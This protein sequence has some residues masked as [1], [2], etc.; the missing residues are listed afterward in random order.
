RKK[1][2]QGCGH[3]LRSVAIEYRERRSLAGFRR[4]ETRS[5][6]FLVVRGCSVVGWLVSVEKRKGK[7]QREEGRR[8]VAHRSLRRGEE[9][10]IVSLEQ[11]MEKVRRGRCGDERRRG[12]LV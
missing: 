11:T 3:S 6:W 10:D 7:K 5:C 2:R 9:D 4:K 1:T 8:L 12:R